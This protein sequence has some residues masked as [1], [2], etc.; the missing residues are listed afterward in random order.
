MDFENLVIPSQKMCVT[1]TDT[2]RTNILWEGRTLIR[3]LW[4]S[5]TGCDASCPGCGFWAT[6]GV[7]GPLSQAT[8]GLTQCST[9]LHMALY[10]LLTGLL[11][12]VLICELHAAQ[13]IHH[14]L[15]SCPAPTTLRRRTSGSVSRCS[16]AIPPPSHTCGY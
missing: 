5:L 14:A 3:T 7:L 4:V 2:A 16:V 13:G 9:E 6:L 12:T 1:S 15:C 8:P 11:E 10:R